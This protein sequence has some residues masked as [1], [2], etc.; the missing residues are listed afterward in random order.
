M[1]KLGFKKTNKRVRGR[2]RLRRE[3]EE[4]QTSPKT[5][6][7]SFLILISLLLTKDLLA[8][9]NK[10]LRRFFNK[11]SCR[12]SLL[13]T[14]RVSTVPLN[15]RFV[16]GWYYVPA[17]LLERRKRKRSLCNCREVMNW[18]WRPEGH[19][20]EKRSTRPPASIAELVSDAAISFRLKWLK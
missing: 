5:P 14:V 20:S 15:C 1:A 17:F 18:H 3:L 19:M 12:K 8:K 7:N 9:K 13:Q 2:L 6:K 10:D 4:L 16:W 11:I